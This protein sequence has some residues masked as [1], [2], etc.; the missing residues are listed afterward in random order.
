MNFFLISFA[1]I[2][3]LISSTYASGE[4]EFIMPAEIIHGNIRVQLLNNSL[5][6]LEQKGPNGF[7][8]RKTFTVVNRE[9]V[10]VDFNIEEQMD[11]KVVTTGNVLITIPSEKNLNGTTVKS[12]SGKT[13][14]EYSGKLPPNSYLPEPS[15][16][17]EAWIMTDTP[18]MIPPEWGAT[19]QPESS[20]SPTS[21]WDISNNAPDIYIFLAKQSGYSI[22]K[23]NFL[24]LTGSIPMPPLYSFGL[25][26][27]R[28]YAYSEESALEIIDTYRKKNIPIDMFVVD[29]DWRIGASKGYGVNTNLFPDMKRFI[30][31]AHSKNVKIMFNDHPEPQCE[32]ALDPKELQFRWEGLTS[33]FRNGLDS[34]WFDRNWVTHLKE[35]LGLKKEVWG[36]ALFWDITQRYYQ[37]RR[38][39]VMSNVHGID[40]GKKN[41]PSH[42]AAHRYPIWWT[43]DTHAEWRALHAGIQNGVDCGVDYLMPYVNE[44][45]G[46]HQGQPSAELYT[47]FM[48]FGCLSPAT[49]PHCTQNKDLITRYPWAFKAEVEKIVGDYI[50]LRYRLIPVLYTAARKAYDN[51]TP[52]MRRCDLYWPEEVNAESNLQYMFGDDLLVAPIYNSAMGSAEIVPSKHLRTETGEPG[53]VGEYYDNKELAGTPALKRIDKTIDFEWGWSTDDPDENIKT[54]NFSVRWSGKLGPISKSAEYMIVVSSDDGCRLWLNGKKVIDSWVNQSLTSHKCVVKLSKDKT[55]NLKL[56]YYESTGVALCRL[57]MNRL[58]PDRNMSE[59]PLWIPPGSWRDLWTGETIVGPSVIKVKPALN[60]TPMYVRDGGIILSIPQIQHT[61]KASWDK[62]IVDAYLSEKDNTQKRNLYEDDGISN[63]YKNNEYA[64]TKIRLS[65][66]QGSS[67]LEIEPI[68]GEYGG[69]LTKR[70]W[71]VRLHL[72]N[73]NI[74]EEISI[75]GESFSTTDS[76]IIKVL[77][78]SPEPLS[79]PLLGEGSPDGKH[80]KP[81]V[82]IKLQNQVLNKPIKI[83]CK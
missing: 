44:D 28:Y 40:N 78:S 37:N 23:E 51:G 77:S 12:I 6:R 66:S 46:G 55:Y 59:R 25:I 68:V 4:G 57:K 9:A 18:R 30:D 31:R 74:P 20:D 2:V 14:F 71:I 21:G 41:Y 34:W 81:I 82:E 3:T 47:R 73:N 15:K 49:R 54:D 22:F 62:V 80:G 79:I 32:T 76:D 11:T 17:P 27:S 83:Q 43:G 63:G 24:K 69:M 35:P 29:T 16:L 10:N 8:D 72:G 45:L 67:E 50:R 48:Q 33:Q 75:N 38:P 61:D 39:L 36:M 64:V 56:E 13:L 7:E 42:P 53:L 58:E 1:A 52:L 70:N 26:H 60:Q 5:I 19:P 65:T